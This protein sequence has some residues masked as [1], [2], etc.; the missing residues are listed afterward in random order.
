LKL[1]YLHTN[2]TNS[3]L[4][5]SK[6]TFISLNLLLWSSEHVMYIQVLL[7]ITLQTSSCHRAYRFRCITYRI[8]LVH[9]NGGL[10]FKVIWF[11]I[12]WSFV[13]FN[14]LLTRNLNIKVDI[15]HLNYT[16]Y[17]DHVTQT[18][19]TSQ[20]QISKCNIFNFYCKDCPR[21]FSD[22]K[23]YTVYSIHK[24]CRDNNSKNRT[25]ESI[26]TVILRSLSI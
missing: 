4:I 9:V 12:H 26:F 16:S 18:H 17:I 23:K 13:L 5:D 22:Y 15:L 25:Y 20:R 2:L 7:Y 6:S 3:Y 8:Y 11:L 24:E 21:V 14:P 1:K 19:S 10:H